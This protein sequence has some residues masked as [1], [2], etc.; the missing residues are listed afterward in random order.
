MFVGVGGDSCVE[1][2]P[3]ACQQQERGRGVNV[4]GGDI[5]LGAQHECAELLHTRGGV[6]C[7]HDWDGMWGVMERVMREKKKKEAIGEEA[8]LCLSHDRCVSLSLSLS[9][10][11]T[12][13]TP[14]VENQVRD[15][16]EGRK[17]GC[18]LWIRSP[19]LTRLFPKIILEPF[20]LYPRNGEQLLLCSEKYFVCAL[21][22]G[23][24]KEFMGKYS[25]ILFV[26]DEC[27]KAGLDHCSSKAL[28]LVI[29]HN[30]LHK[31]KQVGNSY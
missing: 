12:D 20:S 14:R 29:K 21:A 16:S 25:F 24:G 17:G 27:W 7:G 9:L 13:G 22:A 18:L 8:F 23:L 2:M 15:E 28:V 26:F 3:S 1:L 19:P 11:R 4:Q 30:L 5:V 31:S 6:G 10:C